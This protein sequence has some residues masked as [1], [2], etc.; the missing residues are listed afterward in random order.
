MKIKVAVELDTTDEKDLNILEEVIQ[1]LTD[2]AD[3]AENDQDE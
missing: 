2:L 1:A 3:L